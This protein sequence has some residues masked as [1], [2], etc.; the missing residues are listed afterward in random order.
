M[1]S[2]ALP[3][4]AWFGDEQ[5]HLSFPDHWQIEVLAMADAPAMPK[6]AITA[7]LMRSIDAAPIYNLAHDKRRVAIAIDDL[8][9]PTPASQIL[10]ILLEMLR[11]CGL[12]DEQISIIIS[13]GSHSALKPNEIVRKVG[14]EVAYRMRVENHD[15]QHN[16]V[17]TG[18]KVGQVP[19]L[20]NRTFAEA[21]LK[22]LLGSVVPHAFAGFSGGAKMVLPGLANI[23]SI[24]WTHKAVLMGLRGKA[25]TLEGNRFRAEFERVAHHV[26]V[27][28]S[29]N[30]VVNSR[31]EIAGV[32]V[33]DLEAAHRRAAE[34]AR[35]VYV[36]RLPS[37]PLDVAIL[38]AYPKDDELLQAEN[39]FMFHHTAPPGY[40]KED[41]L[42]LLSSACSLGMGHHGLFGPGQRLY[43]KPM[44]KGFLGNRQLAAFMP[45]VTSE[46]FHQ[47]YWEGYSHFCTW[48]AALEFLEQRYPHGARVGVFPC[49]SIQI[50]G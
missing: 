30:V 25:G 20:I 5:I 24:E 29:I 46:E 38:N 7:A 2:Y 12:S 1:P 35:E 10:P 17:D 32:F 45:G 13:L 9:R 11:F 21:D 8:S 49:S 3:W 42:V 44:R 19:V 31:R 27:Q 4:R 36:T 18:V 15:C 6:N 39:A 48:E 14:A 37:G 16:L 22:I 23:E 26:G 34:F 28:L 33:G 50:A 41:G 47:I 43:R 40:L